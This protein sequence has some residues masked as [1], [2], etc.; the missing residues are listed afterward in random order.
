[1]RYFK[2]PIIICFLFPFYYYAIMSHIINNKSQY[3]VE[4]LGFKLINIISGMSG[5]I[6]AVLVDKQLHWKDGIAIVIIWAV[7]SSFLIPALEIYLHLAPELNNF[8]GFITWFIA[9]AVILHLK[10]RFAQRIADKIV[11]SI[12]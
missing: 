9:R 12:K 6:V 2:D 11:D 8:I 1:M 10:D 4:L 5:A 7:V 3:M